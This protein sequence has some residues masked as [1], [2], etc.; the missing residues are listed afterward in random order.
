MFQASDNG[1]VGWPDPV[2]MG[3][4]RS[5]HDFK[6]DSSP[7][8]TSWPAAL[9]WLVEMPRLPKKERIATEMGYRIR[10]Q[11]CVLMHS[12]SNDL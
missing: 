11:N 4:L 12:S 6:D 9:A 10:I 5:I 3:Q 7:H 1:H 8:S 2:H